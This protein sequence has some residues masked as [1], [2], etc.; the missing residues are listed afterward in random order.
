MWICERRITILLVVSSADTSICINLNDCNCFG[1]C[2]PKILCSCDSRV[3]VC[4][5]EYD[6][7]THIS[8]ELFSAR[9]IDWMIC[10][11]MRRE[12]GATFIE[13][14]SARRDCISLFRMPNAECWTQPISP[15][16]GHATLLQE[17]M[18]RRS[19][20]QFRLFSAKS[21][22]CLRQ[23]SFVLFNSFRFNKVNYVWWFPRYERILVKFYSFGFMF[24][25]LHIAF[26]EINIHC[27]IVCPECMPGF[28]DNSL[29]NGA[30]NLWDIVTNGSR[31][32]RSWRYCF[33]VHRFVMFRCNFN[34]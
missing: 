14:H 10:I 8:L 7:I 33:L 13:S 22:H 32:W 12:Y 28:V 18:I 21:A 16:I 11:W 6:G 27:A 19:F 29:D 24:K 1:I 9:D 5:C 15:H 20:A 4:V 17:D 2:L 3:C 23:C 26:D 31:Q 30:E 25:C 34:G